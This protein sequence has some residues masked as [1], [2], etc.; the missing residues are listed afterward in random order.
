MSIRYGCEMVKDNTRK[1]RNA[2]QT[3][4]RI[5]GAAQKAFA[6]S[7]Y[8]QVGIRR[9]AT[10]AGVDSALIKRYFSSKAGLYEAALIDAMIDYQDMDLSHE[11][12]GERLTGRF[13]ETFLD[14]RALSMIVLSA[15]DPQAQTIN[16]K[17]MREHAIKPLVDWLGPPNA[18][19]RAIR[20]TMLSTSF[21][22]Y[23]RQVPLMS[24]SAAVENSTADW[25][26][27]QLQEIIDEG[28]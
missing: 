13:I 7:G 28:R 5:L 2:E 18:E 15:S 20:M 22:I 12:F 26:A 8:G 25:L 21:M 6:E 17:V 3:R 10:E 1:A 24:P 19:A 9:I 16:L 27:R 11:A 4:A 14:T 23:T